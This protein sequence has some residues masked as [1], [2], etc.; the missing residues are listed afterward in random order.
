[1]RND[2]F[3]KYSPLFWVY[4]WIS[5]KFNLIFCVLRTPFSIWCYF[6]SFRCIICSLENIR[7]WYS[8]FKG[9]SVYH[10][11]LALSNGDSADCSEFSN[12]T[13]PF[14]SATEISFFLGKC[15]LLDTELTCVSKNISIQSLLWVEYIR[16]A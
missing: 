5:F 16:S 11:T 10:F 15:F 4:L 2:I 8:I 3:Y 9:K 12:F 7:M 13:P 6:W 14:V 1:M